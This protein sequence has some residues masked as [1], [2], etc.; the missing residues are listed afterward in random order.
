MN[1]VRCSITIIYVR[2]FVAPAILRPP[3]LSLYCGSGVRDA[4]FVKQCSLKPGFSSPE[5]DSRIPGPK[6]FII[7]LSSGYLVQ[8]LLYLYLC[9]GIEY[10]VV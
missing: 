4:K 5:I 8:V 7:R 9:A 1:G 3:N 2:N 6:R 10:R